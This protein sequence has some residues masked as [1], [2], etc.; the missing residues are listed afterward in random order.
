MERA[1]KDRILWIDCARGIAITAIVVG[2]SG[3]CRPAVELLYSFHVPIFFLLSGMLLHRDCQFGTFLRNKVKTL[4]LPYICGYCIL[5]M[6][7]MVLPGQE[8]PPV[9]DMVQGFICANGEH[10]HWFTLNLWFIPCLFL[11]EIFGYVYIRLISQYDRAVRVGIS[12]LIAMAAAVLIQNGKLP[13]SIDLIP[14]TQFFLYLG[15]EFRAELK[16][17]A[18]VHL[19]F[20]LLICLFLICYISNGSV[21]LFGRRLGSVINFFPTAILGGLSVMWIAQ[22]AAGITANIF[23]EIGRKSIYIYIYHS[24][25][26]Q[27]IHTFIYSRYWPSIYQS[28]LKWLPLV[29]VALL[30]GCLSGELIFRIKALFRN[31]S[32]K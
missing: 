16:N 25:F 30:L 24:L 22:K 6:M 26:F 29:L 19:P 3:V 7:A 13:W 31:R 1:A 8:T 20:P 28:D 15:Y 2:H 21:D 32:V 5:S 27:I 11:T 18:I 9:S 4:L 12:L 23:S 14:I 10:G 17:G